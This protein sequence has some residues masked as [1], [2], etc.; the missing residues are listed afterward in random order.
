[1][2]VLLVSLYHPN[3]CEVVPSKSA[4]NSFKALSNV[5]T[6]EAVLLAAIDPSFNALYKSGARITG[7]DGRPV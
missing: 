5:Q 2:K 7:F 6:S 1:V 4:T 3:W